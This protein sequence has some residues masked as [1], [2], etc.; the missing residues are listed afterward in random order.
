M[1]KVALEMRNSKGEDIKQYENGG[2]ILKGFN[3]Y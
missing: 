3:K 2:Y 1:R